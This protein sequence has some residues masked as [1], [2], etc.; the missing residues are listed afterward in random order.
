MAATFLDADDTI[1]QIMAAIECVPPGLGGVAPPGFIRVDKA[2]TALEW[3][4]QQSN[5]AVDSALFRDKKSVISSNEVKRRIGRQ[6]GD[7]GA[8]ASDAL[9]RRILVPMGLAN[10]HGGRSS[11]GIYRPK[12]DDAQYAGW[13]AVLP[14]QQ[15]AA[16]IAPAPP[17]AA[18]APGAPVAPA[19]FGGAGVAAAPAVAQS[20][21]PAVLSGPQAGHV[22]TSQILRQVIGSRE[23]ELLIAEQQL[24]LA[25]QREARLRSNTRDLQRSLDLSVMHMTRSD[26]GK[27]ARLGAALGELDIMS[28]QLDRARQEA[29]QSEQN[30]AHLRGINRDLQRSLDLS[31][32]HMTRSDAGK[33]ARLGAALGELDIV[34]QQLDRA[35]QE[36]AQ[37]E[38]NNAHLRGINR[39][40][41]QYYTTRLTAVNAKNRALQ[42]GIEH[43]HRESNGLRAALEISRNGALLGEEQRVRAVQEAAFWRK[44]A[45]DAVK[46]LS[47]SAERVAKLEVELHGSQSAKAQETQQA[48]ALH[49]QTLAQLAQSRLT[50]S[51]LVRGH[52][53]MQLHFQARLGLA[54]SETAIVNEQAARAT[55]QTE[56]MAAQQS[57]T[58]QELRASQVEC[59]ALRE[60]L[61]GAHAQRTQDLRDLALMRRQIE[62][63][64]SDV[65]IMD[66]Q[67][68]KLC[69]QLQ[70]RDDTIESL[71]LEID[72]GKTRIGHLERASSKE[73]MGLS[74]SS[75]A[76]LKR[77]LEERDTQR[78]QTSDIQALMCC[79]EWAMRGPFDTTEGLRSHIGAGIHNTDFHAIEGA[80]LGRVRRASSAAA[81]GAAAGGASHESD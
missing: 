8:P 66:K 41:A 63:A 45:D 2:S 52:G 61:R 25:R 73:Q 3:L 79:V 70:E 16:N 76:E 39:S 10:D 32:M 49:S 74:D 31:V 24:G 14:I 5:I 67:Q 72:D 77:M 38:Q 33:G 35:R 64:Q 59:R 78:V 21:V 48:Q 69:Q 53:I 11:T 81:G 7:P 13:I 51:N 54:Q 68:V 6:L 42:L 1:K 28:Q 20:A 15:A 47:A 75:G 80:M 18:G 62:G 58:A 65:A 4:L 29:A 71:K 9:G 56:R 55:R 37:S 19:A 27:G 36:A 12:G 17:N 30:N 23:A 26:A 60:D 34:S 46:D 22:I 44:Q 43:A 50:N 40:L 57:H